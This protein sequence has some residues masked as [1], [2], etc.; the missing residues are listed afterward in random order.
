[1]M[2]KLNERVIWIA[3]ITLCAFMMQ[4]QSN[5][6]ANLKTILEAYN[7]E[8]NIQKAEIVDF[9]N[10]LHSTRDNSYARGFE[11]GRTQAGIALA[12]DKAL[13]DYKDGYHAALTQFEQPMEANHSVDSILAELLIDF[14]D[15]ELSA[16]E[17]YWEL[18][19]YMTEDPALNANTEEPN[20]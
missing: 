11:A 14:M 20:K 3:V 12:T 16:E 6:N 4:N 10:Q 17:S 7:L 9:N 19:E 13:Y 15:H 2:N 8:T 18:L 1:M 5:N